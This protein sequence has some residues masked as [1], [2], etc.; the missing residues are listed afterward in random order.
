MSLVATNIGVRVGDAQLLN[1]VDLVIAPGELVAVVGPNGAGKSTLL[2]AIAGDRPVDTGTIYFGETRLSDIPLPRLAALR[3]VVASP[4][5]LA[6]D[7][8]VADI[9]SMGWIHGVRFGPAVH[10]DALLCVLDACELLELAD[11]VFMTLSQGER[12]RV[13]FARGLLQLWRPP[14]DRTPRWL[15]LDE[16]TANLDLGYAIDLLRALK[17]EAARGTG[18]MAIV[19]DLDLGVRFADRV[20]LLE[21][22]CVVATG[23]PE[24]VMTSEILTRVY[25]TPVHV[26]YNLTLGRLAVLT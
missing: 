21:K 3:A 10:D 6:F 11:R 18:V 9:V 1:D 16:P 13:Q 5:Q 19:H 24:A 4:P 12:Q 17:R 26:E 2:A 14:G 25:K 7:Y 22:G 23:K 15:L 20:V 8:T